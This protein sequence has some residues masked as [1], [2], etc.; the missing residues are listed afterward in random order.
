VQDLSDWSPICRF[1]K[2][3]GI[4]VDDA[5]WDEST[6]STNPRRLLEGDIAAKMLSGV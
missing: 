5:A 1:R 4:S 3:V 2:S 6:F